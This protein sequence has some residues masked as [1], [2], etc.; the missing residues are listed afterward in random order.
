MKHHSCADGRYASRSRWVSTWGALVLGWLCLQIECATFA[1]YTINSD[2][3]LNS[4]L[5]TGTYSLS[6]T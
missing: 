1:T 3:Q 6:R 5:N 2:S 4:L